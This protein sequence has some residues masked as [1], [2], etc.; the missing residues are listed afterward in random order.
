MM[1]GD[2]LLIAKRNNRKRIPDFQ[3]KPSSVTEEEGGKRRDET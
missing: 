3:H 2:R 1:N